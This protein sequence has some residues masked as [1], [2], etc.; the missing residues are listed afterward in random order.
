[1]CLMICSIQI[2]LISANYY[3]DF[4]IDIEMSIQPI[5]IFPYQMASTK[6]R[7]L[8]EKLQDL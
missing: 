2:Y 4:D 3:I 6:L 1:M 8:K 7:E 5:L